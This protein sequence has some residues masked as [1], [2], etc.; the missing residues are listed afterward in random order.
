[1]AQTFDEQLRHALETLADRVHSDLSDGLARITADVSSA[2]EVERGEADARTAAAAAESLS[3]STAMQRLLDGF[4]ALDRATSLSMS[5][6]ALAAAARQQSAR[7]A[8]LLVRGELLRGWAVD[9]F[10]VDEG[11]AAGWEVPL[12]AG[13]VLADVVRMGLPQNAAP[14]E[15]DR[16][17]AFARAADR[18]LAAAPVALNG[19]VVAIV[20]GEPQ[21]DS[22]AA[23]LSIVL[24]LLARHA[25]RVL[26]SLTARRLAQLDPVSP[27]GVAPGTPAQVME[28]S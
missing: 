27:I 16:R 18:G 22:D 15:F 6:D 19:E 12:A 11:P 20:C 13:G 8:L 1:M 24:E 9:G 3:L 28:R 7:S 17:P 10:S 23:R 25:A 2:A 14:D 5:L 21:P 4:Q 26:E